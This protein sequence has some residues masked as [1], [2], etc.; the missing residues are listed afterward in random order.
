M[1]FQFDLD[2]PDDP[3]TLT[4]VGSLVF[5]SAVLHY[6]MLLMELAGKKKPAHKDIKRIS[7]RIEMLQA[8]ELTL[9]KGTT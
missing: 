2:V 1:T 6:N 4:E 8:A 5:Q 3:R 7:E 9:R